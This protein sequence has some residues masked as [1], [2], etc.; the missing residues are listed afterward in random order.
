MAAD[1]LDSLRL[2]L[3]QDVLPL[4]LAVV[5]RARKGGPAEVLAAFD[6]TSADPLGQ[7]RQEGEPAASQVR[8]NL[9]RF[10]PG[11][12]NPVM[13]VEVRD[14]A[15]EDAQVVCGPEA[16]PPAWNSP[17]PPTPADPAEL[18]AALG[19]IEERLALLQSRIA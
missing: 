16:P 13:K 9:D 12:G 3:M 11:L 6:G 7:L 18:L 5:E 10:Q 14:V 15:A 8:E 4:G 19:R 2:A 17:A 1:P